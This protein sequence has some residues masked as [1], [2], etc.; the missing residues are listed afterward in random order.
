MNVLLYRIQQEMGIDQFIEISSDKNNLDTEKVRTI[1]NNILSSLL[2]SLLLKGDTEATNNLLIRYRDSFFNTNLSEEQKINTTNSLLRVLFNNKETLFVNVL[3]KKNSISVDIVRNFIIVLTHVY[4]VQLLNFMKSED[5][6]ISG[7]MG[8]LLG[9]RDF[10]IDNVPSEVIA[11][12][13]MSSRHNLAQNI[14][15]DAVVV[16]N[17]VRYTLLH[18][19]REEE[20]AE[21]NKEKKSWF[22]KIFKR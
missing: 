21:K 14:S 3:S 8:H 22:D 2:V 17:A 5:Y 11:L 9:E 18:E 10:F 4:M 19:K 7:L 6:S 13:E 20:L 1:T 12:L 16:S 15:A